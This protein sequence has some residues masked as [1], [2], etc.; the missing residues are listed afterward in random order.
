MRCGR[1]THKGNKLC[2][3]KESTCNLCGKRGHFRIVCR[4]ATAA[5]PITSRPLNTKKYKILGSIIAA[6]Q[7]QHAPRIEIKVEY[8][9]QSL[10]LS[11]TPDTGADISAA[12]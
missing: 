12:G 6:A 1:P 3:A 5:K 11:A 9:G 10:T 8:H 7:K 4:S 2:P